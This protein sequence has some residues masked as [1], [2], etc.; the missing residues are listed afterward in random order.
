MADADWF[1]REFRDS[2]GEPLA[3]ADGISSEEIDIQLAG[4]SIP[5]SMRAYYRVAGNHWLNTNHNPLRSP[6]SLERVNDYTIFMD[7]NQMVVQ[8]A[9]RNADLTHDDPIVYQRQPGESAATW[10]AEKYT[11]SRFMIAMWKWMLTGEEPE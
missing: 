4:S 1:V 5:A 6:G 3:D 8:W 7:E 11:F 2:L 9:I 10:H